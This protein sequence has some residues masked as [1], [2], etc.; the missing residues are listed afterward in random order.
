[1]I[2][3]N[4]QKKEVENIYRKLQI[5]DLENKQKKNHSKPNQPKHKQA[6]KAPPFYDSP[7]GG[8]R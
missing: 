6:N 7:L 1:M 3:T 4:Y 2:L 8:I 5:E